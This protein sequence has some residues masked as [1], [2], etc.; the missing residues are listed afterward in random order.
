MSLSFCVLGS[1][2]AGNCTLVMCDDGSGLRRCFLIDAGLSPR[3]TALRMRTLGIHPRELSAILLTHL[4]HDHF[5]TGWLRAIEKHKLDVRLC[6][7]HRHRNFA[8]RSGLSIRR[9]ELFKEDLRLDCGPAIKATLLAH[10]DLGSV[11]FVIE[12]DG[13]RLG[14]ATDLGRVPDSLLDHFENLHALAIESNYD[15]QMQIDSCR[16]WFLKRRIMG[17]CGHLSNEQS[18]EAVQRIASRCGLSHIAL[19]HLSRECNHPRVV[20][21]LYR[22]HAPHLLDRLTITDQF[23]PTPV[24]CVHA[25]AAAAPVWLSPRPSRQLSLFETVAGSSAS[26][27]AS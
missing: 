8:W 24:L 18:L 17:G 1:G 11:G 25:Q 27:A 12:L 9:V 16:P 14:Y 5:Y 10:D 3:A 4:D 19:L 13:M 20:R 2:S 6:I 7:H 23:E 22:Q 21:K 26:A 15:R